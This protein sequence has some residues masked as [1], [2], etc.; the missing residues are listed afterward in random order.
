MVIYFT[1]GQDDFKFDVCK[2]AIFNCDMNDEFIT[3]GPMFS[4]VIFLLLQKRN[5]DIEN[6]YM[7]YDELFVSLGHSLKEWKKDVKLAMSFMVNYSFIRKDMKRIRL[8]ELLRLRNK[9]IIL[10]NDIVVTEINSIG[11]ENV[12]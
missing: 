3:F 1:N 12:I 2:C 9:K 8:W 10:I 4:F 11:E 5:A 6:V 7:D